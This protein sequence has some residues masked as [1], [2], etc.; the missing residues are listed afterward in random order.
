MLTAKAELDDRLA[1]FGN[2]ANDYVS[3]PFHVEELAAR[4]NAQ[5]SIGKAMDLELE[6]G[7]IVLD[8]KLSK[9]RC[10]TN[11]EDTGDLNLSDM[12]TMGNGGG[13]GGGPGEGFP[14][15]GFPSGEF[16]GGDFP[17]GDFSG[18]DFPGGE[19]PDG[20]VP[21]GNFSGSEFPDNDF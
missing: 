11:Q 16:P 3:K 17:S 8:Y 9:L 2:E 6:F 19:F 1:G 13:P 14:G 18:G 12:G 4:V 20:G 10:I 15:G 5:L 7:D 21:G